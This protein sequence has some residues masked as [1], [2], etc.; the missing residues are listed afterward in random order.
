AITYYKEGA[1]AFDDQLIQTL[2]ACKSAAACRA[3]AQG[4]DPLA[5]YDALAQKLDAGPITFRFPTA[6]GT[7]VERQLTRTDLDNAA[8]G[9]GYG[10]FGRSVFIRALTAATK[11]NYVPLARVAY[12]SIVIDPESLIAIPDPTYSDAMY[13]ATECQDYAFYPELGS[14]D[15]RLNAWLD[16]GE[17]SGINKLRLGATFYVDLP[18][19]YWPAQPK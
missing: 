3:D 7:F 13:Y 2:A 16:E 6:Q 15:A 18:C 4:G 10:P 9:Y 1:R 11:G 19:L 17:E 14:T 5:A 12:D 8:V